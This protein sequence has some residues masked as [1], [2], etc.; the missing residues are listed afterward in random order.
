M[1]WNTAAT[2]VEDFRRHNDEDMKI[3]PAISS[4]LAKAWAEMHRLQLKLR[5]Y[6][7]EMVEIVAGARCMTTTPQTLVFRYGL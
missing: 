7:H 1:S 4:F 3:L 6:L 2:M 5:P